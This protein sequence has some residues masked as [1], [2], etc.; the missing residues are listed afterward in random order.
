MPSHNC[1]PEL[2]IL[3]HFFFFLSLQAS[4][5]LRRK[6]NLYYIWSPIWHKK[7]KQDRRD[8]AWKHK[9]VF[10]IFIFISFICE[11]PDEGILKA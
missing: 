8:Y 10:F 5:L 11:M 9:H 3:L 7:Y 6:I 2:C 1:C 4:Q